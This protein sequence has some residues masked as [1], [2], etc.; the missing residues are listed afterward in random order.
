MNSKKIK[1]DYIKKI[2][3]RVGLIVLST[4]SM[5]EKDFL[6]VFINISADLYIN[7]IKN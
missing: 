5:I 7:R 2:N 4:D 6:K 1:L 3:P